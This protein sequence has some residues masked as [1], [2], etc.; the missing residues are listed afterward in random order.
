MSPYNQGLP[1]VIAGKTIPSAD[2][3][4][5]QINRTDQ[6]S[7]SVNLE[8]L[9][10]LRRRNSTTTVDDRRRLDSKRLASYG[11]DVTVQYINGPPGGEAEV[12]AQT[13]QEPKPPADAREVFV[14]HGRNLA[15]NDALFE[16]LRAIDL[17]PLEWSEAVQATGKSSPY[18][19]E[20]LEAAFSRAHAV[21]V[22]FTPDDEARLRKAFSID[23][24]PPHE[25]Q[26]TGQARPN[27]LFEAGMAMAGSQDRTILVELGPLRPFS[28]ISGLHV[29]RMDDTSQRRQELAQRLR[30]AGCPVKL[31]GMHWHTT[32]NFEDALSLLSS[33]SM[34]VAEQEPNPD[35]APHLSED[36]TDLLIEAANDNDRMIR[37]VR[38]IRGLS[39]NTNGKRFGEMGNP[40]SEARWEQAIWELLDKG[41][42]RDPKG[43]GQVFEVTQK[44]FEVADALGISR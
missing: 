2:I 18:I 10:N 7:P 19:G 41:L 22:L 8:I 1:I 38:T 4:R 24:D 14:V 35:E 36:T 16:F 5:I 21:V 25:T 28:D 3:D 29:V 31:D 11:E 9:A 12:V 39:I 37:M 44:G 15:A 43:Q 13:T 20:I 34:V 33:E 42:I 30:I 23:N 32:G 40:R 6:D 27:V 17:H 26:L